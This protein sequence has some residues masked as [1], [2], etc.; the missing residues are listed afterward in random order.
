MLEYGKDYLNLYHPGD[1]CVLKDANNQALHVGSFMECYN[2]YEFWRDL[3]GNES[4]H[5]V[6]DLF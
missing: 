5:Y 6:I 1:C 2:M 4:D 3:L